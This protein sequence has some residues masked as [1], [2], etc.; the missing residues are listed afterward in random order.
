MISL[1]L[2]GD[3]ST[4]KTEGWFNNLKIGQDSDMD[5]YKGFGADQMQNARHYEQL[6]A[7]LRADRKTFKASIYDTPGN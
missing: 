4:S 5:K 2:L 6:K 3:I 7:W 1:C